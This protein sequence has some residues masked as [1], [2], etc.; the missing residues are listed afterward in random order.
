MDAGVRQVNELL[1]GTDEA[2]SGMLVL[3]CPLRMDARRPRLPADSFIC[4]R[5]CGRIEQLAKVKRLV[6]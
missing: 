2:L 5:F 3:V 4:V 6:P 1:R